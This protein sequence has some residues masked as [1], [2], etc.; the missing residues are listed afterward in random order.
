RTGQCA[1]EPPST[2]TDLQQFLCATRVRASIPQ[3]T[4]LVA[5][6]TRLI[7]IATDSRKK[8]ALT[9]VALNSVGW[10]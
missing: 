6:L 3:Y 4:K 10:A 7:D 8:P 5:P 9:R 2:A 1:L